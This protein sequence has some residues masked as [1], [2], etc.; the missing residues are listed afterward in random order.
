MTATTKE[1][2]RRF[3]IRKTWKQKTNF[4]AW[5][6]PILEGSGYPVTVE[7]GFLGARNIVIGDVD[8]AKVV[9]TAH[10]DTC[11]I[12]PFPNFVT[13]KAPLLYVLYQLALVLAIG[14]VVAV[15]TYLTAWVWPAGTV[16]VNEAVLILVLI[17]LLA[18]P[19]NKH[20]ANDNTSGTTALI[21]L[22]MEMP[23]ELRKDTAFVLFD[24]EESGLIGSAAFA[25]KHRKTMTDKLVI[26]MDCVSDGE[27]ML[28]VI[29][30]RARK[31]LTVLEEAYPP[32]TG[33]D[34]DFAVRGYVYPSDQ[35][36]FPCGVGVSALKA[37]RS[38]LLYMDK[39]HTGRDRVYR[40]RNIRYLVDGGI[41]LARRIAQEGSEVP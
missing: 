17:L 40:E 14:A 34:S 15:P 16:L 31:Y 11:V 3:E 23:E 20:T 4:I 19:A 7:K 38:G 10:Y 30:K 1:I 18:G 22:A 29:R 2:F 12:L 9:Y 25:A 41:R 28:F 35:S 13:P 27:T 5:L 33:M 32:E 6:K 21:D 24:L 26:N 37:T 8:T 39:I 36:N